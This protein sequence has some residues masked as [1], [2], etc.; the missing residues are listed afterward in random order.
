MTAVTAEDDRVAV[1]I[2][3]TRQRDA[4]DWPSVANVLAD[5]VQ[6]QRVLLDQLA[7]SARDGSSA[8][9]AIDALREKLRDRPRLEAMEARAQAIAAGTE[10][11]HST[12]PARRAADYIA[13]GDAS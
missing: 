1:A 12:L 11:R 6:R 9:R 13:K 3:V 10:P 2:Q 5:E 7:A 4:L 8:L